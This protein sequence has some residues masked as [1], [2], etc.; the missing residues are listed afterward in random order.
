M[1]QYIA[2][3]SSDEAGAV[4]VDWVVLSAAVVGLAGTIFSSILSGST[5]LA[6]LIQNFLAAFTV[7]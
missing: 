3:F 7:G 4:T 6:V 2:K 1:K 5:S